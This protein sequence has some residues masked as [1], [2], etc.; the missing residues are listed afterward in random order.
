MKI[1]V[2]GPTGKVGQAFSKRI[3]ADP[4][5]SQVSMRAFCHQRTLD[6][7]PRLEVVHGSMANR[8][9]VSR[10]MDGVSHVAPR[11]V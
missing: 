1:L 10:A 2:T 5:W 11:H 9:D 8:D 3:L 7:G 6:A 4:A